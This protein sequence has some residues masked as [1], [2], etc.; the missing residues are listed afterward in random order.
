MSANGGHWD[1][2]A[3]IEAQRAALYALLA[4]VLAAPPDPEFLANLTQLEGDDTPLGA[5]LSKLA[6]AAGISHDDLA[7]EYTKLFYGM[8]QGGEVLPYA[9]YYLTGSLHDRPLADLRGDMARLGIARGNVN[10]EPE[11]H[12]AF[13]LEMMHGLIVGSFGVG[14]TDLA[15]QNGFFKAHVA[16]W[17]NDFFMDLEAAEAAVFFVAVANVGRVFLEVESSAFQMAA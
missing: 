11:D 8:G 14:A 12:I 15:E 2:V 6:E 7:E 13:L 10:N 9:S 16:T 3:E 1:G 17:A 5:A 4:R